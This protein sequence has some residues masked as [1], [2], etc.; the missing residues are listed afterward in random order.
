MHLDLAS[1]AAPLGGCFWYKSD[2]IFMC[3]LG[4]GTLKS[5]QIQQSKN[6]S[7]LGDNEKE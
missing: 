5:E 7:Y 4:K 1:S 2:H 6:N 3:S